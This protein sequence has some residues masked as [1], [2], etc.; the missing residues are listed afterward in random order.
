MRSSRSR[1]WAAALF[2]RPAAVALPTPAAVAKAA[3]R[4]TLL[5]MKSLMWWESPVTNLYHRCG[6]AIDQVR[7]GPTPTPQA[8]R[9][10]TMQR[11]VLTLACAAL[12]AAAG[13][14]AAG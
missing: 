14:H 8:V 6:T 13:A 3:R 1:W 7:P 4:R 12:V 10:R 5:F 2:I 11:L 9:R